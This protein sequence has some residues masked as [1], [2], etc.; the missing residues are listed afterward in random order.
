[1]SNRLI[2]KPRSGMM[3]LAEDRDSSDRMFRSLDMK[4]EN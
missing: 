1:M 2:A 3:P 4:I